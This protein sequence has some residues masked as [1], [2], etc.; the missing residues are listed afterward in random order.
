MMAG[1]GLAWRLIVPIPLA[2]IVAVALAWVVIP[3]IMTGN[4]TSEAIRASEQV[5][6]Q[7]KLIR[8]YYTENV[9]NKLVKDGTIRPSVDHKSN[10]K[11]VPLPA[12]MIHDLSAL[13]AKNDTTVNLYSRYPFPNRASR[14]LDAFQQEAWDHLTKNPA[15]TFARNEVRDGRQVVRVAMAD[16]MAVQAC[17]NCH[18]TDAQSPKK[19]W[20][21]GDV[22]GVL[23]VTSA[24][25]AQLANG[26]RLSNWI[27]FG[28]IVIGLILLAI[29]LL[30]ARSVTKPIGGI[31]KE[32]EKLSAGNHDIEI[33][34]TERK[35]E[36]GLMARS[37]VSFRDAALE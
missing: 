37:V 29:T 9:V 18:N 21:L 24:I 15:A 32:I 31:V 17:V 4:A 6:A 8:A 20:N 33:P 12:T 7:F 23:E 25:D 30:T 36:I 19:N 34:G 35:D 28:A 10:D 2:L 22:R 27:I 16:T 11:L 26:A 14:Q 1:R 3:R 5:V 13:L